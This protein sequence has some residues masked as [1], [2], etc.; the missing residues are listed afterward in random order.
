MDRTRNG[1]LWINLIPAIAASVC[2]C[3]SSEHDTQGNRTRNTLRQLA[4]TLAALVTEGTS[5]DEK[6]LLAT[7]KSILLS[8]YARGLVPADEGRVFEVDGWGKP[9]L[10]SSDK[11]ENDVI[12]IRIQSAGLNGMPESGQGDDLQI[13]LRLNLSERSVSVSGLNAEWNGKGEIKRGR[14]WSFSGRPE[15]P[16]SATT[17]RGSH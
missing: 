9:F 11:H 13:E 4:R 16:D 1:S 12:A 6:D 14:D 7:P 17:G 10:W 8:A 2:S 5:I 15:E 3:T